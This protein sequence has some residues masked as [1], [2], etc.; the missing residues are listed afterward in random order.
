MGSE[1]DLNLLCLN[2][3]GLFQKEKERKDGEKWA[4]YTRSLGL[5]SPPIV[6]CLILFFSERANR[7]NTPLLGSL[8]ALE[9]TETPTNLFRTLFSL[10][11]TCFLKGG[12]C[13]DEST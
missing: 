5:F 11:T 9:G 12:G 3:N 10:R 6:V 8:L 7:A 4:L 2:S 13:D 1:E